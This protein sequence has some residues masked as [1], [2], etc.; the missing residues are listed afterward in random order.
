[1]QLNGR[2]DRPYE[3]TGVNGLEDGQSYV[4]VLLLLSWGWTMPGWGPEGRKRAD[5]AHAAKKRT[6]AQKLHLL[7]IK[8]AVQ[9]RQM[10]LA[11]RRRQPK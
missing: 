11:S 2:R 3:A 8:S 10:V 5:K 9:L 1:M 6:R 7:F 4:G